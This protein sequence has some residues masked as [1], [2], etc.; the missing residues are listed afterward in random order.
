MRILKYIWEDLRRS[1]AVWEKS[2]AMTAL[3]SLAITAA[4][5][6]IASAAAVVQWK[7][8]VLQQVGIGLSTWFA[9]LFIFVTPFRMWSAEKSKA[10]AFEEEQKPKVRIAGINILTHPKESDLPALRTIGLEV[11]NISTSPVTRCQL[12]EEALINR[13]GQRSLQRRPFRMR[14]ESGGDI[15]QVDF[16][17]FFDLHG[18][19]STQTIDIV[20]L[21]ERNPNNMVE[22]CYATRHDALPLQNVIRGFFP[23]TLTVRVTAENMTHPVECTCRITVNDGILGLEIV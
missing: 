6:Y 11:E 21:D 16:E 7:L 9:L 2:E 23:H 3:V 4:V 14:E 22:F 5:G 19:G 13:H 18:I 20:R 12:R 15:T 1:F 10:E 8:T 17:R